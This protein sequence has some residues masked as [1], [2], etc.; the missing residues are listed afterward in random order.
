MS[1]DGDNSLDLESIPSPQVKASR[2][3]GLIWLVPVVAGLIAIGLAFQAY[4]AKGPTITIEFASA[5]GLE[6]GKTRIKYKDV[7]VGRVESI[8]LDRNLGHVFITACM[9]PEIESHLTTTTRFWV[10]RA[11]IG[12]SEVSGLGT[13][14]SGVHIAMEPGG[15][16]EEKSHFVGLE[17]PPVVTLDTAGTYYKLRAAKM[18]SIDIGA[19]VY[20]RQIKVGQVVHYEM[21][22][23]GG[24]VKVNVFIRSPHDERVNQNTRFW[25]ASGLDVTVDPNGVRI[26]TQSILTLLQGGVAFET[27]TRLGAGGPVD[28]DKHIFTLFASHDQV[29]EPSFRRKVY[30]LAYFDGTIRGLAK[31]APVEFRGIK[32]GEVID[33][34]LQFNTDDDSFRIPVLC[35]IE[36]DRIEP[37]GGDTN[38]DT[39]QSADA[40]MMARLVA[41]G[42]RAQLRSGVLLTG[43]LY[44]NLDIH[45]DAESATLGYAGEYP[46]LPTVPEPVQ[47][48]AARL[49]DFLNRLEKLPIEQ[50]GKDLGQ[51]VHHA[52]QLLSTQ[53]LVE[54]VVSLNQ[55]MGQL[56]KFTAG[57]NSD[58][59]PRLSELLEQSHHAV[60]KGQGA[61]SV[62]EKMLSG[63]APLTHELNQTL[64]ELTRAARALSSLAEFLERNPQSLIYGKGDSR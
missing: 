25:N 20:F 53:E 48:I 7:E 16:G 5:E 43:Q 27:P 40:G 37:I 56:K 44:I 61:L 19:P 3:L 52:K 8:Q 6:A 34:K 39:D 23:L 33:L 57:L 36:P 28:A 46:I 41:K 58:L 55:S 51:A 49:T 42:L 18:G 1:S 17:K 14:F 22:P 4:M 38:L 64:Q 62:A 24:A 21:E 10:V 15:S 59:S 11:R 47:E 35:A 26:D 9:V 2:R 32:I 12:T 60:V 45:P 13:L 54:A 31:G 50:I 63:E 30:F 29:A